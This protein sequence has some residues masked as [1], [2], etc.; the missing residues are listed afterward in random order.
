MQYKLEKQTAKYMFEELGYECTQFMSNK[1]TEIVYETKHFIS[2]KTF[3]T[4]DRL[5][6]KF[7]KFTNSDSPFE[8][9]RVED[10]TL[11]EFKAIQQQIKELGW[12]E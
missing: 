12:E 4:F 6:K 2:D 5:D 3:I 7:S 8:S 11:A 10:I 9:S 1:K